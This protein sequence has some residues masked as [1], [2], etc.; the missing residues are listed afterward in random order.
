MTPMGPEMTHMDNGMGNS[1]TDAGG[2]KDTL[3]GG[4][5]N[6][7]ANKDLEKPLFLFLYYLRSNYR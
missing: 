3:L 4:S 1:L 2:S 5:N 6:S 7:E